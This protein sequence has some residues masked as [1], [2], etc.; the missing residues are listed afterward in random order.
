MRV[1][2]F[3]STY[4]P[5]PGGTTT[6]IRN[7]I[8]DPANEHIIYVP[9]PT[10]AQL[11]ESIRAL[12]DTETFG[13]VQVRRV[14]FQEWP[15]LCNLPVVGHHIRARAFVHRAAD[16][17]PDVLHGHNPMACALAAQHYRQRYG[18][19][20]V[21]EVHGLMQDDARFPR[22]FG[23]V[24][25]LNQVT[26]AGIRRLSALRE[27]RVLE[28]A[29]HIVVQTAAMQRRLADLYGL[30][31]ER[32]TVIHNGVDA[33]YFAPARWQAAGAALRAARG[34]DERVVCLYAGYL[35]NV[36]G[37]DLLI[38]VAQTLSAEV[39]RRLTIVL[40]GRGP[41]Q[42]R[43]AQA[44]ARMPELFE[45][46]GLVA[47]DEIP[48]YYA[49]ADVF[50]IPRPSLLPA[51][52]LVPMKLLEAMAMEKLV[53]V[54]DV[55]A[56]AEIVTD[57]VNG[58]TFRKGDPKALADRLNALTADHGSLAALRQRA[59]ADV[60]DRY[61]WQAA[62]RALAAAYTTA[63]GGRLA[64]TSR[65]PP[66]VSATMCVNAPRP[67]APVRPQPPERIVL[68]FAW[69]N[70]NVGDMAITPG[71]IRC[72]Q[73]AFPQASLTVLS[74]QDQAAPAYVTTQTA[75]ARRAP[76]V[77]LLPH[78]LCFLPR[79]PAR[80]RRRTNRLLGLA[81]LLV[82]GLLARLFPGNASYAAL[83][84]A[85]LIIGNGGIL[86]FWDHTNKRPPGPLFDLMYPF[87]LA[88]RSRITHGFHAQT[89][90]PFRGFGR[91]LF[92]W[93]FRSAQFLFVR[94]SISHEHAHAV[95]PPRCR[96]AVV[97]D[98]AFALERASDPSLI[99]RHRL[100]PGEFFAVTLR[101][102]M[103]GYIGKVDAARVAR[104]GELMRAYVEAVVNR[105]GLTPA[106]VV[107]TTRDIEFTRTVHATLRAPAELVEHSSSLEPLL[108]L[109]GAAR[110]L[111]GMRL[112]SL[113]FAMVAGTPPIGIYYRA[114]SHKMRGIMDDVGLGAY[115]LDIDAV[116][117][118][119]LVDR[120]SDLLASRDQ[121]AR[122][123]SEHISEANTRAVALLRD[124]AVVTARS[125]R[126]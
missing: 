95:T 78:P 117:L 82:P 103:T 32:V 21:Y 125:H 10:P 104:Y 23:P 74:L 111:V 63:R 126:S 57:G 8:A 31:E 44:A 5:V 124:S 15:G 81:S 97:P 34:W 122:Q 51:E 114:I 53:L 61:T 109:Y 116:D 77:R 52:T 19:P 38:N 106:L 60:L 92:R 37:T 86:F 113:I 18:T 101:A 88:R 68:A 54:S 58:W 50:A 1:L 16:E 118:K 105:T 29:D 119:T 121:L 47:A 56:M 27:K 46:P 110:F 2:H 55:A 108:T 65:T 98:A 80:L 102:T 93:F 96:V 25:P 85:D 99:E 89:V 45:Y 41:L 36:N 123:L 40:V 39:R 72:L 7:L 115:V 64:S 100:R 26:W 120:T 79:L 12:P 17:R 13:H 33:D 66:R 30:S 84:Q 67:I 49:A 90:G 87:L 11:P 71:A 59:R 9:R 6:R 42:S 75:L 112:H 91:R 22:V 62:R 3:A 76:E 94:E 35:N 83:R 70:D 28:T 48:A 14:A 4:L 20:L 107:Q 43:A 24:Q 73:Q 69:A